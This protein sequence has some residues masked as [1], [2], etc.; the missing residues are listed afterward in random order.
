VQP[1]EG[2]D[3]HQN[4]QRDTEQPQQQISTHERTFRFPLELRFNAG[5]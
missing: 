5:K 4:W 3:Q 2:V 1:A